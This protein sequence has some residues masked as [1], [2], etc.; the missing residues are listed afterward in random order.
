MQEPTTTTSYLSASPAIL[1]EKESRF[2]KVEEL[3]LG[4]VA[5]GTWEKTGA[6]KTG[7]NRKRESQYLKPLSCLFAVIQMPRFRVER[8]GKE[9]Y[10]QKK[11]LCIYGVKYFSFR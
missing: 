8:G 9:I 2:W 11:N 1:T 6:E 4:G 7:Y 3:E 5:T 10:N